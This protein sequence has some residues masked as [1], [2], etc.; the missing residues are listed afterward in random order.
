MDASP[1]ASSRGTPVSAKGTPT[2][3]GLGESPVPFGTGTPQGTPQGRALALEN[4]LNDTSVGARTP[5]KLEENVDSIDELLIQLVEGKK[6]DQITHIPDEFF[7]EGIED[8]E[9]EEEDLFTQAFLDPAAK[10]A[11]LRAR[12]SV[13]TG[14]EKEE[15]RSEDFSD[16]DPNTYESIDIDTS[17]EQGSV[18]KIETEVR[19]ART[20]EKRMSTPSG[21]IREIQK[22][23]EEQRQLKEILTER[24][25]LFSTERK[26]LSESRA[27][28]REQ[29]QRELS[30]RYDELPEH[31]KIELNEQSYNGNNASSTGTVQGMTKQEC[32]KA[33]LVL[34]RGQRTE[35]GTDFSMMRFLHCPTTEATPEAIGELPECIC[36][37]CGFPMLTRSDI[38]RETIMMKRNLGQVSPEHTL[39]MTAGNALIGLPTRRLR[40]FIKKDSYYEKETI[41]FLKKG[42]M[43]SH[44]WCNEVKNA[45]RLVTWPEGQLPKPNTKNINWL[46]NY[47]W[48]GVS[49]EPGQNRWFDEKA[50]FVLYTS[51]EINYKFS[52]LIHYF[53]L[54]PYVS[55]LTKEIIDRE[56]EKWLDG[57]RRGITAFLEDVCEDIK[58]YTIMHHNIQNR[59]SLNTVP[60]IGVLSETLKVVYKDRVIRGPDSTI[61]WPPTTYIGG[62]TRKNTRNTRKLGLKAVARGKVNLSKLQKIKKENRRT[63]RTSAM[64]ARIRRQ[65]PPRTRRRR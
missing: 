58:R 32:V 14:E 38:M 12:E 5:F 39:P 15:A 56:R 43:Y 61:L 44:F 62:P 48:H 11:L 47:M 31:T 21:K 23:I 2:H 30:K 25:I 34:T 53:V 49:R 29:K 33:G 27:E 20:R 42:L 50:C 6:V 22:T 26:K 45:L 19:P 40:N 28:V 35:G 60:E 8:E 13:L 59:V 57:R 51:G 54:K 41:A 55:T 16:L 64:I 37:L 18:I 9:D 1:P 10:E 3:Y 52:N 46:L 36:W 65:I 24:K 17:E 7:E 4:L 63:A